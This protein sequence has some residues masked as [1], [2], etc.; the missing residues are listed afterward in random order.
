MVIVA[1]SRLSMRFEGLYVVLDNKR[2]S[3]ESK[4]TDDARFFV[5]GCGLVPCETADDTCH[6]NVRCFPW[7]CMNRVRSSWA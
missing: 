3:V 7:R 2:A 4:Q 1:H 6:L 5:M